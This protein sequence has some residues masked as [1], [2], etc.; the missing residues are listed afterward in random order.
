MSSAQDFDCD[1]ENG[2]V[3]RYIV[4][5]EAVNRN[6]KRDAVVVPTLPTTKGGAAIFFSV[7]T[8]LETGDRRDVAHIL[9]R[10]N[11]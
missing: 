3:I 9:I 7:Y 5:A 6:P 2:V 1:V 4:E 8:S 11:R 10:K